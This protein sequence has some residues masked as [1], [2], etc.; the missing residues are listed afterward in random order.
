MALVILRSL[1]LFNF[2]YRSEINCFQND[3]RGQ[4]GVVP[5]SIAIYHLLFNL[6]W[7]NEID[8][9]KGCQHGDEE[10]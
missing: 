5:A 9:K 3:Q 10:K 1:L 8:N 2:K 6:A 4:I 7:S